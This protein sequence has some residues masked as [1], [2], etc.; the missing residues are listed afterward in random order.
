M[1]EVE[2]VYL[3]KARESLESAQAELINRRFNSSA[4]RSYYACFQAAIYALVRAGI[5]PRRADGQWGHEFVHG[6]FNGEL[7]NRRHL[8][9]AQLR[10]TLPQNFRLRQA[11][12]YGL[13]RVSEVRAARAVSRAQEFVEAVE[14]EGGV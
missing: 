8:Y 4:N 11:A 12:D 10:G 1:I 7:V 6:Q 5:G 2:L 14:K 3:E 13:D 9:P